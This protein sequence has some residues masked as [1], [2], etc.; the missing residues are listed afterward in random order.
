LLLNPADSILV[1]YIE[2][3]ECQLRELGYDWIAI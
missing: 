2:F 3:P 1:S